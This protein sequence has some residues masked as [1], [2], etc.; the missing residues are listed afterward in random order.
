MDKEAN[1]WRY[2]II[3]AKRYTRKQMPTEK[4]LTIK[5]MLEWNDKKA[6]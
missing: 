5:H 4:W 2:I 6:S 1:G 3:E